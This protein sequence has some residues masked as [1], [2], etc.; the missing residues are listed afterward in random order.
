MAL[1]CIINST[2]FSSWVND[3]TFQ[4]A[5]ERQGGPNSGVMLNGKEQPDTISL[6]AI[7]TW[8][9]NY[10]TGDR[11][12]AILQ[13]AM[14]D[15]VTLTYRDALENADRTATFIPEL[16]GASYAFPRH[17]LDYFKQ[18]QTLT[19]REQTGRTVGSWVTA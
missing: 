16:G 18:G 5:Y 2:D 10:L 8:D 12:A 4:I 13:I 6:K 15:T 17:G 19:L 1:T 3:R 9:L 7:V 11:L 14:L